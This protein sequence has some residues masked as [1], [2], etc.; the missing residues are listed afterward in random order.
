MPLF[1][2]SIIG[3]LFCAISFIA[4]LVII[5][6]QLIWGGSAYG[7]PS[8][9]CIILMLSGIQ[10]FAIEFSDNIWQKRPLEVKKK[11]EFIL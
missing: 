9:V 10:L 7:W 5:V 4:I 11:T 1:V 3:I 6:R 2:S 8:M